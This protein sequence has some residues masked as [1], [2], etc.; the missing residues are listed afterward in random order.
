[1]K[2]KSKIIWFTGLSG[3]GKS[4]LSKNLFLKLKQKSYQVH[5]LDGDT[6]RRKVKNVNNFTK[7]SIEKNNLDI[8][9]YLKKILGK[10]DFIL[11]AVISPLRI[12]RAKAKKVFDQN[13]LEVYVKCN[14]ETLIKRDTKGLYKLAI[15]RKIKNLV[16][17]NSKVKY[18][19]SRYKV[20]TIDTNKMNLKSSINKIIKKIL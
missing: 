20:L 18:E 3:S 8:I 13:Y 12:T 5:L 17:F 10:F 9:D 19:T 15:E 14:L 16:G 6:Y 7:K 1:M 4:T 11:V 2:K